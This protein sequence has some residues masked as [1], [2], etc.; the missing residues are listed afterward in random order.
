[1]ETRGANRGDRASGLIQG[2]DLLRRVFRPLEKVDPP[3]PRDAV[4]CRS[5]RPVGTRRDDDL[6]DRAPPAARAGAHA[7]AA[8]LGRRGDP[9]HARGRAA[10]AR[11]ARRG[12]RSRS[13]RSN[14]VPFDP[15]RSSGESWVPG[16]RGPAAAGS[17]WTLP[18]GPVAAGRPHLV[19]NAG[20]ASATFLVLQGLGEFDFVPVA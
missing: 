17:G 3:P 10:G 8:R 18:G 16:R 14:P 20:D 11:A 5:G 19:T 9:E 13:V 7:P 1:M 15:I 6:P 12:L 4:G 2:S